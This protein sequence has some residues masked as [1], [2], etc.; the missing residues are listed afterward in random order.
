MALH[1]VGKPCTK[2][3]CLT[4]SYIKWQPAKQHQ[5]TSR[6]SCSPNCQSHTIHLPFSMLPQSCTLVPFRL[7]KSPSPDRTS[8]PKKQK[9]TRSRTGKC[10]KTSPK[11][12]KRKASSIPV[13]Q[14]TRY[15]LIALGQ[16]KK[17]NITLT[18][19]WFS[20]TTRPC[21]TYIIRLRAGIVEV[22]HGCFQLQ[23][24]KSDTVSPAMKKKWYR[25]GQL[26][27]T[28]IKFP[29][30]YARNVMSIWRWFFLVGKSWAPKQEQV[31]TSDSEGTTFYNGPHEPW[32]SAWSV[33]VDSFHPPEWIELGLKSP[34]INMERHHAVGSNP[35]P[36]PGMCKAMQIM[37]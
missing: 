19:L 25:L 4:G 17:R 8:K 6:S 23:L 1:L 27:Q 21:R 26:D 33:I 22:R 20:A 3:A 36:P 35:K 32:I 15:Q 11:H 31:V 24:G 10:S 16:K 14:Y 7:D 34:A 5:L 30:K 12:K 2:I 37:G 18:L 29:Y 28:R 9:Q 13:Y